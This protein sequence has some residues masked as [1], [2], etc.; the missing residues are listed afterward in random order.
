[1]VTSGFSFTI[2]PKLTSASVSG[3]GIPAQRCSFDANGFLI[4]CTNTS[5]AV[6]VSWTGEGPL[7]RETSNDH[8]QIGKVKT[9]SHF[10]GADRNAAASGTVAGLTVTTNDEFLGD[11]GRTNSAAVCIGTAFC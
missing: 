8:L 7:A 5:I 2:D 6:S 4:G 10:N 1:D 9:T 3:S 11:I